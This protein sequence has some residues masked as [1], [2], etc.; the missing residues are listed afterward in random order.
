M[1][2]MLFKHIFMKI[3]Q[4]YKRF[5]SLLSMALLGIGFYAGIEA[6]SPDILKTLDKFYDDNN[7]YDIKVVSNLGLDD[8]DINSLSKIGG[9]DKVIGSYET[10]TYL[11]LNNE[12]YVVKVMGLNNSINKVYLENGSLPN[13]NNEIVVEKKMLLDN[14]LSIGDSINILGSNKK[15]VGTVISPLYFSSER[16]ST[17]LGSGKVNYYAYTLEDVLKSD[18]YSA[19]YITL[20]NTKN[21]LTNS[22]EYKNV[23]D[24]AI[25]KIDV[26]KKEREDE[27]YNELYD[28]SINENELVK[29]H[30]YLYDRL[31][32]NSYKELIN[33]SDNIKN[34][35]NVFP[36][37]FFVIAVLVS[38]ISMMR[39]IEED[40]TENGTLK[41]LGYNNF[42]ITLKYVIYSLLA[43]VIGGI[44]GVFIGSYSIP[45]VIWNIYI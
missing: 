28:I 45:Y 12:Q 42:Y 2:T 22:K 43:T 32:N 38:L 11:K 41:S 16:P 13:G 5:L 27:K 18:Y 33:A 19:I 14:N 40:R 37:I 20:N 21:M 6:C 4:N 25:N 39:M 26:I 23:I 15:I 44:L 30:W 36:L 3:K 10:D 7:V 29:P 1:K 34:L 8:K 17:N 9:F 35:G 31:D 24:D